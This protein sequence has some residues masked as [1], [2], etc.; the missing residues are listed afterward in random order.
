MIPRT[1][2]EWKNCIV[3]ECRI[4]LT[5]DFAA[6]RLKVYEDKHHPETKAFIRLYGEQHL[7]NIIHWL[8]KI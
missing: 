7:G 8:R 4:K 2:E 1:F 5:K 3:N 6:R